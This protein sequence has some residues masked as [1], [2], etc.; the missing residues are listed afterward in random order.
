MTIAEQLE[1]RKG[2][3]TLVELAEMF[4][5]SYQLTCK[6]VRTADLPATKITG[7]YWMVL[8]G[9]TSK[10]VCSCSSTLAIVSFLR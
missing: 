1:A 7:S 3:M 5:I 9:T 2:L 8:L 10:N 4:G 6:W